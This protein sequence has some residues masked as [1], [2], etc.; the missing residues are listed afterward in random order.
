MNWSKRTELVA[1]LKSGLECSAEPPKVPEVRIL[2]VLIGAVFGVYCGVVCVVTN[3]LCW[4][5]RLYVLGSVSMSSWGND[6]SVDLVVARNMGSYKPFP[7]A[8]FLFQG[9]AK[10]AS[11]VAG[12]SPGML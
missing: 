3:R 7:L 9:I 5:Q 1:T 11:R 12:L 4:S 10:L 6:T 2:L 8:C